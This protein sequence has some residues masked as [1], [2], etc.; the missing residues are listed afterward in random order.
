MSPKFVFVVSL[1]LGCFLCTIANAWE[2][3]SCR[4]IP[5]RKIN[6]V[7]CGTAHTNA[8]VHH[9]AHVDIPSSLCAIAPAAYFDLYLDVEKNAH[10]YQL[11]QTAILADAKVTVAYDSHQTKGWY[12]A[13]TSVAIVGAK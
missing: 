9:I 7:I 3:H 11:L 13:I 10:L 5:A 4:E 2:E 6:L 1:L 8:D 12:Y